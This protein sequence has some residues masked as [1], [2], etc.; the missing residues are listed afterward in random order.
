MKKISF[1]PL[2]AALA[3]CVYGEGGTVDPT[4]RLVNPSA[5]TRDVTTRLVLNG[6]SS[7]WQIEDQIGVFSTVGRALNVPMSATAVGTTSPFEGELRWASSAGHDFFAYYPY[8]TSSPVRSAVAIELPGIQNQSAGGNAE[9]IGPIDFMIAQPLS[10]VVPGTEVN[11]RFGHTFTLLEFRMLCDE[12]SIS[13][14]KVEA[15]E[16]TKLSFRG[17]I[18]IEN[19]QITYAESSPSV[20]LNLTQPAVMTTDRD[21]TP[22]LY[23][24]ISPVNLTGQKIKLRMTINGREET[25][26]VDG[27]YFQRGKRYILDVDPLKGTLGFDVLDM[28][29]DAV[30][31][32]YCEEQL[33][34]WDTDQNGRLSKEEAAQV[35]LINL[36]GQSEIASL[37]G[38]A[39]FAGLTELNCANNRLTS[40]N[41]SGLT[42]LTKLWCENNQ[43]TVLDVTRNTRL[44]TL[45]CS[46]NQLSTLDVSKNTALTLLHC[47]R[48]N[49]TTLTLSNNRALESLDCSQNLLAALEVRH[50]INLKSL[51][52]FYNKISTLELI[53]NVGLTHLDVG[54]NS[55]RTLDVTKLLALAQFDCSSNKLTLIDVSKNL[56]LTAFSCASNTLSLL[57]VL[58]NTKLASLS[59]EN[60]SLRELDISK[61]AALESFTANN[62]PGVDANFNVRAWFNNSAIPANFTAGSWLSGT[63]TVAINYYTDAVE[64][65][66]SSGASDWGE[67]GTIAL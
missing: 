27:P 24:M 42:A 49:L 23:M 13:N 57:N 17:T 54:T 21:T 1:L 29:P 6:I 48:N 38:L 19:D 20:E 53:L 5:Q 15:P 62:N 8:N 64:T 36:P 26:E 28:I 10:G 32:E 44:T 61:N 50:N 52:C 43:I 25:M 30:F 37:E 2:L 41:V 16:G 59:C 56:E 58:A 14:V 63:S 40:L 67:G 3:S 18:N 46:T 45:N 7:E 31:R 66:D 22:P 35:A 11:F 39:Y 33:P 47:S 51:N 65:G 60:N 55:L 9:H 12:G 34:R 4:G